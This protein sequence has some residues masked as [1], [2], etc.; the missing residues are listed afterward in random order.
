MELHY[1]FGRHFY[2][3]ISVVAHRKNEHTNQIQIWDKAATTLCEY[4][5][6]IRNLAKY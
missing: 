5:T 3:V 6:L 1:K 2:D 4:Y